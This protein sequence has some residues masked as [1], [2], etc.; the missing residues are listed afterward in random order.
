MWVK[1][2]PVRGSDA[3]LNVDSFLKTQGLANEAFDYIRQNLEIDFTHNLVG[4]LELVFH[5]PDGRIIESV[6]YRAPEWKKITAGSLHE[7]LQNT[8]DGTWRSDRF[9]ADPELGAK[10]REKLKEINEAFE[11][12]ETGG[13]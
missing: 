9:P 12:F 2:Q 4:D 10:L 11:A 3:Y 8:V 1:Y 5:A 13:E 7:L 6:R